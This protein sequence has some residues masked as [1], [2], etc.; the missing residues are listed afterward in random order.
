MSDDNSVKVAVRIRPLI[1]REVIDM[2]HACTSVTK[3]EPQVWVGKDKAFTFDHVFD[4]PS[5]QEPVYETCVHPLIEGC[6][7]GFNATVL[8]Y[9]QT[10]SGKTYTMGTGYDLNMNPHE[11][12][13]IPRAVEHLFQGIAQRQQAAKEEGKSPPEFKVN[14]Q[15]M[16]LYNEEIFDLLN[17]KDFDDKARRSSIKIHEDSK[18]GIYTLGVATKTVQNVEQVMQCLEEGALSR[19]TASTQMNVQSSRSHAIFTLHIKQQR[20]VSLPLIE[21]VETEGLEGEE[22]ES[23]SEFETLTAKFH[24]VDLAG[25]ERLKRTGA[26]G[27]RAK[28]GISINCGL[29][30]LGNVISALGDVTRKVSHVPYRDSKLTRLLQDSLGGNSRT[31]MIACISPCDRDFMETL[32]TLKY[33]NRAKNIKNKITVNQDKSSQTITALRRE[34]QVLQLELMEYKQGKRVVNEDGEEQV[35]DMF[36]ENNML[37]AENNNFRTRVKALQETIDR[38]TVKN[39][40]LLAEKVTG[41]WLTSSDGG[42][43]KDLVQ[44]Y[45]KEVEELRTKLMESEEVCAQL[46]KQLQRSQQR[47][48]LSPTTAVAVSGIYDVGMEVETDSIDDVLAEA[49]KDIQNL[50]CKKKMLSK[51]QKDED[52]AD[53]KSDGDEDTSEVNGNEESSDSEVDDL[54]IENEEYKE[55]LAALTTEISIKQKLIE[56]LEL[57]Q[58]RLHTMRMHYEEKLLQLQQKIQETQKERDRVL[59]SM[60]VGK[61]SNDTEEKVR[62]IKGDFERKLNTLQ[63]ELRKMQSAQKQHAQLMKNQAQYER[64]MRQLK[65]EVAEMKKT[66]VTLM[67]KMKDETKR[68][69][70]QEKRKNRELAQMR[71]EQRQ[72]ENRIRTLEAENRTKEVVLRRKHEEVNALRRLARPVSG[73]G[74]AITPVT[75]RTVA[76]AGSQKTSFSPK[77]AK[78]KW[79]TLE[80][81][82]DKLVLNKQSVFVLERDMERYL[83]SRE[84]LSRRLE[85]MFLKKQRASMNGKDEKYIR[86]LEDEIENINANLEYLNESI[87]ECQAGILQV[88]DTKD[89]VDS[90]DVNDLLDRT[91]TPNTRYL[92]EK[93]LHMAVNQSLQA[94]QRQQMVQELEARLQQ[95]EAN[96]ALHQNLLQYTLMNQIHQERSWTSAVCADEPPM[97]P[98]PPDSASSSRS[99]SPV[100]LSAAETYS[101]LAIAAGDA[102]CRK[103]KLRRKTATPQELLYAT[104]NDASLP[105]LPAITDQD[106]VETDPSKPMPPVP[107]SMVMSCTD[108]DCFNLGPDGKLHRVSSAPGSLK[109]VGQE[110]VVGTPR[111]G[112]GPYARRKLNDRRLPPDISPLLRRKFANNIASHKIESNADSTPPPSPPMGQRNR[113][114]NV[115]SRLTSTTTNPVTK[116][117]RGVISVFAGKP[118]YTKSS[119]LVCTHVAE[120]HSKAVLSLA[121]TDDVLFS[122]SKDR[123]VKIWNLH[124]GQEIQSLRGHPD[125]VVAVRYNEYTR[126]TFSVSTAFIKVWDV[127]ENPAKCVRTL[128]SS[129]QASSGPALPDTASRSL[130]IPQG[131]TRINAIELNHYGNLLFSAASNIV[132]IWDLRRYACVGKLAGGHQAA[133]MC[134]AVDDAEVDSSTVVTGSKDHYIKVFEIPESGCGVLTPKMNLEPPHYDGIQSLALCNDYLFSGSRDMCIKKWDLSGRCLVQSV[135]QAHKDWVCALSFL[136]NVGGP[137]VLLS[138]CRGG[139]LKLWNADNCHL[140]GEL[141]AHSS[142]INAIAVNSTCVFTASN[143]SCKSFIPDHSIR[144]WQL[145]NDLSP[146]ICDY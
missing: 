44:G 95:V 54:E 136:P 47:L 10:G 18:G 57:G 92:L 13:I 93:L 142:P 77:V 48:S 46:R 62:K 21:G 100:E 85:K 82:I 35:N 122:S 20:V 113:G 72:R 9:G 141:R 91:D 29:L 12:G 86:D 7:E 88:E 130:Q 87:M 41:A 128:F 118:T 51:A 94:A 58:R 78:Q 125:N 104:S 99:A 73:R 17:P 102:P 115:F 1:P 79:Q 22:M 106:E 32:N 38:L 59:S 137:P 31:L 83:T 3:G 65:Q 33:A 133:V 16:E 14:I 36:Y 71:K 69:Q 135:N 4:S 60:A 28:E 5:P 96:D 27:D 6:F 103:S 132:R 15:F 64:Q 114:H 111:A 101:N 121:V 25:S 52:E 146:E 70:E 80:K 109:E 40:E 74:G 107:L 140:M 53:K 127:R 37:Q 66:K 131:E 120:G 50:K 139:M 134:M 11:R 39:T 81:N 143:T 98:P 145:R 56:Q 76:G 119:P 117:D 138:S 19:T 8:A 116:P 112:R 90:L 2:C 110:V 126:L 63:G 42:D 23:M 75:R 129:G 43:V 105:S 84:K 108:G 34:I 30:A 26:T 45:L 49:R 97:L 67:T 124:T 144:I 61:Q 68:H 24:F 55:D 123:T 89:D